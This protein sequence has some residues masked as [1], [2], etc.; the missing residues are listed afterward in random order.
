[1]CEHCLHVGPHFAESNPLTYL[2]L[3]TNDF[4]RHLHSVL[5]GVISPLSTISHVWGRRERHGRPEVKGQLES[6]RRRS[7]DN[8][9]TGLKKMT[10]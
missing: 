10:C 5:N 4:S 9:Q 1:M 3:K 6:T 8:I 7:Q 2:L